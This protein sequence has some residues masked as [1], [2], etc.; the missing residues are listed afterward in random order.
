MVLPFDP[1]DSRLARL[2][3]M[4]PQPVWQEPRPEYIFRE[5]RLGRRVFLALHNFISHMSDEGWQL[6]LGLDQAGYELWGPKFSNDVADVGKIIDTTRPLTVIMQDKREWDP[7]RAGCFDKAAAFHNYERLAGCPDVF[8]VTISKDSHHDP[9]YH[10]QAHHEIGTHAWIH[11]YHPAVVKHLAPWIRPADMIRTWHSVDRAVVP[12]YSPDNRLPAVFSGALGKAFYP[13]RER[14]VTAASELPELTCLPHPGYNDHGHRT[15]TFLE[16]ISHY[17]VLVAT[18]SIFGYAL[19]KLIEGTACGCVVVTDLPAADKLPEID[20][21]LVRVPHDIGVPELR[22]VIRQAAADYDPERQRWYAGMAKG[23]YDYRRLGCRLARKIETLRHG[24]EIESRVTVLPSPGILKREQF[25][26]LLNLRELVGEAVEI[27][28]HRGE[29]AT[30]LVRMWGGRR[31]NCV[32]PWRQDLPDYEQDIVSQGDREEDCRTASGLLARFGNRVAMLRET[33][34]EAARRW[35]DSAVLDFVYV[36][37]NHL[38]EYIEEDVALWWDRLVPNGI[39]A[40]H[41]FNGDWEGEVRPAVLYHAYKAGV[42]VYYVLGDA[43]S[44]YMVKPG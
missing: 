5:G 32:D 14:I 7:A 21:N 4:R 23:F 26:I 42:P 15:P 37:G 31:L 43:A 39:L 1:T 13:L 35:D 11:Y 18:T 3:A 25:G 29:F 30:M 40:G 24:A 41:D 12:P 17:K 2:Q 16:T 6:Q 9:V 8:R 36:D 27:G 38:R 44:W 10:H 28:T 20:G 34:R 19:R 33:S 22:E